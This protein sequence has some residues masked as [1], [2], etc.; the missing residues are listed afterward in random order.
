MAIETARRIASDVLGV[1]ESKIRIRPSEVSKAAE[2]LTREDVRSLIA[3]GAIYA[4]PTRGVS[5][6]R[7]RKKHVQK[8]LGRRRGT[9]SRKGTKYSKVSGKDAWMQKVRSQRKY[10]ASVASKLATSDKRKVYGMIKGRAFKGK[11]AV[12]TYLKDNKMLK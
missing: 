6:A 1:G 9:G 10:L 4:L 8:T 5:R 2:A 11:A 7:G 12:E 3:T